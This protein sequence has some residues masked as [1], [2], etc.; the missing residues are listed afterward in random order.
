LTVLS[1]L[2]KYK[3]KIGELQHVFL[4]KLS[5]SFGLVESMLPKEVSQFALIGECPF[6]GDGEGGVD[7]FW[8]RLIELDK[9]K[10]PTDQFVES[11]MHFVKPTQKLRIEEQ[12]VKPDSFIVLRVGVDGTDRKLMPTRIG[13][14]RFRKRIRS[15]SDLA[16]ELWREVVDAPIPRPPVGWDY[17]GDGGAVEQG[18]WA[19]G[20][21]EKKSNIEHKVAQRTF[22]FPPVLSNGVFTNQ[23]K[24][25]NIL[26]H[27][28]PVIM[29]LA[30]VIG[31]SWIAVSC[32]ASAAIFTPLFLGRFVYYL[33]EIPDHYTHDP[34]LFVLGGAIMGPLVVFCVHISCGKEDKSL[35]A[36][37]QEHEE[38]PESKKKL[39]LP[40][41]RKMFVLTQTLL[42]WILVCPLIA[43]TLYHFFFLTPASSVSLHSAITKLWS[44]WPVGFLLV[45]FWAT[46]CYYGMFQKEF[47]SWIRSL[48]IEGVAG[49]GGED[50]DNMG[51]GREQELNNNR[52]DADNDER[53]EGS[54]HKRDMFQTWQG[55][56]G[57]VGTFVEAMSD[58]LIGQEWDKVDRATFLDSFLYPVTR[59]LIVMLFA[60]MCACIG[61][62]SIFTS[63]E[64]GRIY[65]YR[66]STSLAITIQLAVAF[67]SPLRTWYRAAH[68]AARDHRYLIGEIL[69]N[70]Q[71]RS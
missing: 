50:N 64:Y 48:L 49:A 55:K 13:S 1:I 30:T 63:S 51:Q 41:L 18:R 57:V 65:L 27:G 3:N 59:Q 32:C 10:G 31:L 24:T 60:P 9:R 17:L 45:N 14:Y 67:K 36:E 71:R 25:R 47:W 23:W 11:Q 54:E 29:K 34:F 53:L 69:L 43:G 12:V 22:F 61:I 21:K 38:M 58:V 52:G 56:N 28:I 15:K 19:W 42:L 70:Y 4:L 37:T 39:S 35:H 68:K 46:A 2:E 7:E 26:K 40:P 44:Y 20:M 66:C 62:T 8:D 33:L 6:E 5:T 16:I